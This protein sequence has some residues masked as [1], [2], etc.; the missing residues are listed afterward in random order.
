MI[1][2]I[3]QLSL[4]MDI[5]M[6]IET[7]DKMLYHELKILC[8]KYNKDE[9]YVYSSTFDNVIILRKTDDTITNEEKIYVTPL[10]LEATRPVTPLVLEATRPV[11]PLVLEATRPVTNKSI[12]YAKYKGNSFFVVGIR[13]KN[14]PCHTLNCDTSSHQK[15]EVGTITKKEMNMIFFKNIKMAFYYGFAFGEGNRIGL[16][17]FA[18]GRVLSIKTYINNVPNGKFIEWNYS[19]KIVFK[20]NYVNGMKSG[21]CEKWDFDEYERCTYVN[22]KKHGLMESWYISGEKQRRQFYINDKSHGMCGEWHKNGQKKYEYYCYDGK[23]HGR[24]FKWDEY[25][26]AEEKITYSCG[27]ILHQEEFYENGKIKKRIQM[28]NEGKRKIKEEYWT[29]DG[30]RTKLIDGSNKYFYKTYVWDVSEKIRQISTENNYH[31]SHGTV[32][33]WNDAGKLVQKDIYQNGVKHGLCKMWY[34][35]GKKMEQCEYKF[36]EKDGMYQ[37]WYESGKLQSKREYFKDNHDGY[38]VSWNVNGDLDNITLFSYGVMKKQMIY[39]TLYVIYDDWSSKFYEGSHI[40]QKKYK[41]KECGNEERHA[42]KKKL[43]KC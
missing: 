19:G 28:C 10:V 39:S 6:D 2:I 38:C 18:D 30:I 20:C 37:K 29:S 22:D 17:W 42:L 24:F 12:K 36:G 41:C 35:N 16:R 25:G 4:T 3:G 1:N 21:L 23:I 33:L 27:K 14:N 9:K 8:S 5:K 15:Y 31:K 7:V 34:P 43:W 13:P 26:I 40:C 11:T 32:K